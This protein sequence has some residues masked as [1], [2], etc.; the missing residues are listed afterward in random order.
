MSDPRNQ[1]TFKNIA[2]RLRSFSPPMEVEDYIESVSDY[3]TRLATEKSMAPRAPSPP[4]SKA[5][6]PAKGI[7]GVEPDHFVGDL[8]LAVDPHSTLGG[9][10]FV[11]KKSRIQDL[12]SWFRSARNEEGQPFDYHPLNPPELA[13]FF[14]AQHFSFDP[15]DISYAATNGMGFREVR[16]LFRLDDRPLIESDPDRS[17][18]DKRF[19]ARFGAEGTGER[20]M[21]L[22]SVHAALSDR[23]CNI[24]IDED[25][26]V[27]RNMSGSWGVSPDAGSHTLNELVLKSMVLP[28]LSPWLAAHLSL[29]VPSSRTGYA[30][31]VGLSLDLPSKNLT[32]SATFTFKCKCMSGGNTMI[33]VMEQIPEGHSIGFSLT[34]RF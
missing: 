28:K 5:P 11:P 2:R 29:N 8:T 12:W 17:R 32:I 22:T 24:H 30:P 13:H 18:F 31:A 21:D 16:N 26:F 15:L 34:K 14:S 10:S 4:P 3:R 19:G 9:I 6:D 25:G 1:Q 27:L 20:R 23:R 33:E 7:K